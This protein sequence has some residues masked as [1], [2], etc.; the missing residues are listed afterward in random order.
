[1]LLIVAVIALVVWCVVRLVL[2]P[3]SLGGGESSPPRVIGPDDDPDFLRGLG[4]AK[5]RPVDPDDD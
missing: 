3:S 5:E 1:M 2:G 4:R